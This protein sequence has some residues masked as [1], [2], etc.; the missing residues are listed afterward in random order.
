MTFTNP[1]ALA[2]LVLIPIL[3]IIYLLKKR[4][5]EKT[6]SSTYLWK[7]TLKYLKNRIPFSLKNSLLLLLQ[8]LT[9]ALVSLILAN[10]YVTAWETGEVIVI[11]D[12]SASMM[13]ETDGQSR[14]DRARAEVA[15]L[16]EDADAN[17]RV[18]VI[19]AGEEAEY[20]IQRSD[21]TED[22]VLC[23]DEYTCTWGDA[24]IV[25]ALQLAQE[26]QEQNSLA[27]IL[28]Y[29]DRTYTQ[30]E[31]IEV[32]DVTVGEWNVAAL[33]LRNTSDSQGLVTFQGE[34]VSYGAD[35]TIAVA[36]Y[37]DGEYTETCIVT[38][39]AG[40]PAVASFDTAFSE[41]EI[42]EMRIDN[43]ATAKVDNFPHDNSCYVYPD[44]PRT[45]SIQLYQQNTVI[46][47]FL[48]ASLLSLKY[49]TVRT[50]V[51]P[52]KVEYTGYD[53]YIFDGTV[54]ERIPE[55]GAVWFFNA[56][57]LPDGLPF[58]LGAEVSAVK[59]ETKQLLG[60]VNSGTADY[61]TLSASLRLT[62]T[63]VTRYSPIV[64]VD[65]T[66]TYETLMTV[67][68]QPVLVA[69]R[70]GRVPV[71]VYTV[72]ASNLTTTADFPLMVRNL[73]AFSA[74]VLFEGI[75]YAIGDTATVNVPP[76]AEGILLRHN[77]VQMDLLDPVSGEITFTEPGRYEITFTDE[78]GESLLSYFCFVPVPETE[79]AIYM[80][81][82]AISALALSEDAAPSYEPVAIWQYLL[83]LLAIVYLL[84]WGVYHYE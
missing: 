24:D 52:E 70:M 50:V 65:S 28:L 82:E 64:P 66:L 42:A 77:D 8:I 4:A 69:A 14:F 3:I 67:D 36:L 38:C 60:G 40:E 12:G 33:S 45:V 59:G 56:P 46:D 63:V 19:Y 16:A 72:K 76:A 18:T 9:V 32:R 41:F 15:A 58:G 71:V 48:Y 25:G 80:E 26:V 83:L 2:G 84:E 34:V 5:V 39:K 54:P 75:E 68:G 10:P 11:V 55:D 49:A 7:L 35:V 13:T 61:G 22:I 30:A 53:I 27:S 74:P 6:V 1:I 17:H 21:R 78:E 31:G 57:S 81:V 43:S 37:V 62:G 23:L 44:H 79:T 29:T 20:A 73:V 47:R 51:D